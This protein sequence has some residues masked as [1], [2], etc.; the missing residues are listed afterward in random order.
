[1]RDGEQERKNDE[2]HAKHAL[3][4][5]CVAF[6]PQDARP[7]ALFW[8]CFTYPI[9]AMLYI[10]MPD[11]RSAGPSGQDISLCPTCFNNG[12]RFSLILSRH[13]F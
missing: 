3:W 1:M 12:V 13:D 11:V 9:C 6:A 10:S 7:R 8:F 4:G 2:H 5:T